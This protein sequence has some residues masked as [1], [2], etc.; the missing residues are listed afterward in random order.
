MM[1]KPQ[2]NELMEKVDCRYTLVSVVAKRARQLVSDPELMEDCEIKPVELAVD[3]LM[4]DRLVYRYTSTG[5]D[6]K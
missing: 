4:H 1:I 5:A 3:D 6:E 2:L